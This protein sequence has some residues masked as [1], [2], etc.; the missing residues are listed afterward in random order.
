MTEPGAYKLF[1]WLSPAMPVGAYSYSHGLESAV[2]TGEV[3]DAAGLRAYLETVLRHGSGRQDGL[4]LRAAYGASSG[5]SFEGWSL[6][7]I[8]TTATALR[9]SRELALESAAQGQALLGVLRKAWPAKALD[10]LDE[11]CREAEL[12]PPYAV[13][14]GVAAAA[15]RLPLEAALLAFLQ[16]SAANL[17]SA[18]IRLIPLGQSDGQRLTA[19]LEATVLELAAD[20][21]AGSLEELGS[22]VPVIELFSMAHETQY[23]RLF[24]S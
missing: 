8:V 6:I 16:A 15:H 9:G 20:V 12:A 14:L 23:T 19:A 17:I 13:V 11:L 21:M 18:G 24:R 10:E 1:A 5:G 2:E 4:W 3:A 7:E 22:A